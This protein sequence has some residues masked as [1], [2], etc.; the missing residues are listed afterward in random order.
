MSEEEVIRERIFAN[1]AFMMQILMDGTRSSKDAHEFSFLTWLRFVVK[2]KK[3]FTYL[4][5]V[6]E[7][8]S[9]QL[10]YLGSHNN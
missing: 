5:I 1:L 6:G 7:V 4:H 8:H 2:P 10:V 9:N 3:V